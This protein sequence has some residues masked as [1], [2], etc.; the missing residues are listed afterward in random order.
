MLVQSNLNRVYTVSFM[1]TIDICLF[2]L[3]LCAHT[4][5]RYAQLTQLTLIHTLAIHLF[6]LAYIFIHMKFYIYC[7]ERRRLTIAA[8]VFAGNI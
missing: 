1:Q 3:F 2:F 7:C 8:C 4:H 5:A 6:A